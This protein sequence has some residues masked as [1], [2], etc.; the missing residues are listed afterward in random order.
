[1]SHGELAFHL[2]QAVLR[3]DARLADYDRACDAALLFRFRGLCV[4]GSMVPH[5]ARRLHGSGVLVVAAIGFP[6]GTGAAETKTFETA[7]AAVDGADEIDYVICVRAALDGDLDFVR[8]E[9]DAVLAAAHG[10]RVKA[11]LETGYLPAETIYAA[12]KALARQGVA[13][14]KTSTGFGP[15]N[16]SLEDV[17][18]LRDAIEG[19]GAV[20]IKVSGGIRTRE[21][22]LEFLAAGAH[23]IGTSQGAA[24]CGG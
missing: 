8:A 14:V 7:R 22:V 12:A 16:A 2:D 11:I 6:H 13:Y 15:R 20:K 4:P 9:A 19:E 5:I 3:P 18:L 10:R 21:Q 1:M 23:V 17:R 24:I